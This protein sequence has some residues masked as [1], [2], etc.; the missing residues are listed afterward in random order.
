MFQPKFT[1]SNKILS[2]IGAI[3]ACREVILNAPLIPVYETRFKNE[4]LVRTVHHGTRLE[5]NELEYR[6][7]EEI[8]QKEG[9]LLARSREIQ[10]VMNYRKVLEFIEE[11]SEE[12]VKKS[13]GLKSQVSFPTVANLKQT[14]GRKFRGYTEDLLKKLH[15]IVMDK[16][17]PEEEIGLWRKEEAAVSLAGFATFRPPPPVEIPYLISSFLEWLNNE[18]LMHP[19][20][21]AGV[22]HQELVRIHPFVD[23]NGRVARALT[24]LVLFNEGYDIRHFFSL[25]EY[26]DQDIIR[27]YQALQR[28]SGEKQD[29]FRP[30][31]EESSARQT[32]A[33]LTAWLEYFVEGLAYEL[34]RTKEKVQRISTDLRLKDR[35]GGEPIF[36][37]ERQV[38]II[39]FVENNRYIRNEHFRGL[40]PNYA[41]DTVLRDI[42]DLCEKKILKKVG[43][44]KG[45]K[46]IMP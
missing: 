23:G 27:Y 39:E 22:T 10:E 5:G 2:G 38:K 19:V 30:G 31:S 18:V 20:L 37:N 35:L 4:A 25:E 26:Y 16:I 1:I 28:V 11:L 32:E 13:A 46:Y 12:T 3:E 34:G 36:L 8:I 21:K 41:E 9:K 29:L 17:V 15:E 6:E 45:A 40:F 43:R 7:V 44:T 42:R 14:H 24:T 33:D